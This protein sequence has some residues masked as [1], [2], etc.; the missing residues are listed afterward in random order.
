MLNAVLAS[1]GLIDPAVKVQAFGT[2]LINN[3]WKVIAPEG[4]YILQR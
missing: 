4:E 2:G 1:Y 3:T